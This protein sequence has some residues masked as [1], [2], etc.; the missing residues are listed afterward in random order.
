M[1]GESA[2]AARV[3]E[4]A[5]RFCAGGVAIKSSTWFLV[6]WD[7]V[8]RGIVGIVVVVIVVE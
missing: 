5:R 2:V 8:L 3:E 7:V 1:V 4:L 6:G